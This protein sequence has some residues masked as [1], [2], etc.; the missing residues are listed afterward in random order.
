MNSSVDL[1]L[2]GTEEFIGD[3]N[4]TREEVL[5]NI[6]ATIAGSLGANITAE[7]VRFF[8]D[9][10]SVLYYNSS[11]EA[12]GSPATSNIDRMCAIN[13]IFMHF[14]PS[15]EQAKI[16]SLGRRLQQ[17]AVAYDVGRNVSVFTVCISISYLRV[18]ITI[19]TYMTHAHTTIT[20]V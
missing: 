7:L 13:N 18:V 19:I 16:A 17:I 10:L 14:F 2:P 20:A 8:T 1:T 4:R 6:N 11:F 5:Y 12:T 9:G 3:L 15:T